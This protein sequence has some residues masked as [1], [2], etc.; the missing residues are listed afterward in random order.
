MKKD[1]NTISPTA[2]TTE[3]YW[4]FALSL[5]SKSMDFKVAYVTAPL[6]Q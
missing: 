5:F 1:E 2:L 6:K 3:N 4:D